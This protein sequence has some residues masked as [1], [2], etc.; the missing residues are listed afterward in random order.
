MQNLQ[1]FRKYYIVVPMNRIGYV[2]A[3]APCGMVGQVACMFVPPR[4]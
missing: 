4:A 2:S 1:G 3:L